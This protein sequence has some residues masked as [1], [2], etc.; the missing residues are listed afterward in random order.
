MARTEIVEGTREQL[1]QVQQFNVKSIGREDLGTE[2]NFCEAIPLV[3]SLVTIHNQIP[4]ACLDDLTENQLNNIAQQAK[5]DMTLFEAILTFSAK[6]T[7]AG[8]L[9]DNL[10]EKIRNRRD[11]LFSHFFQLIAYGVARMTDTAML[12]TEARSRIQF[13]DQESKKMFTDLSAVKNTADEVLAEI[14]SVAA[15]QGV[16]QKAV[17]FKDEA[18]RQELL[19][20]SWLKKTY[21]YASG[22]VSFAILSVFIHKVEWLR[23]NDVAEMLQLISSKV[24]IFTV[25][26][27]LLILAA[28]NYA[29]YKH[30]AVVNRHRQNALLTF[31]KLVEASN[32]KGAEDI[33]LAHA[34]SCIFSPQ[35]TG[36]TQGKSDLLNGS[37]SILEMVTRSSIKD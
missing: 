34:A 2:L 20:S 26:A 12:E 33:V 9:R 11:E 29:N 8:D 18:E 24:L 30:N 3:E 5:T 21:W 10:I 4:I 13:I 28:R 37:K 23:P 19:A 31:R 17:Y 6:Q 15:E 7:N 16:S 36:F 14:R 1:I 22:L 25:L 35:I 32:D 27:Y